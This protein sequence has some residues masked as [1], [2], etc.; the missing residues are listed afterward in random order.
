MSTL[1]CFDLLFCVFIEPS[2]TLGRGIGQIIRGR[3][4]A[5]RFPDSSSGHDY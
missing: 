4:M 2:W 1:P 5:L 3:A